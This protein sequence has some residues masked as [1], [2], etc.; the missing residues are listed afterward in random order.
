M[1]KKKVAVVETSVVPSAA[2]YAALRMADKEFGKLRKLLTDGSSHEIDFTV[3]VV[4]KIVVGF[5]SQAAKPINFGLLFAY[6][7]G[8]VLTNG[9][10]RAMAQA[11]EEG[12]EV[13]DHDIQQAAE[14]CKAM[15]ETISR[16]ASVTGQIRFEIV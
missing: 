4:G 13:S 1:A 8:N 3:R 7:L 15:R 12:L 10:K 9:Q 2:Q 11:I 6:V 14:F 16:A 5:E